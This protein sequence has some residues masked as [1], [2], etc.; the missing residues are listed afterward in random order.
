M[1]DFVVL[2]TRLWVPGND[3]H[4][5]AYYYAD[6]QKQ[7]TI[8]LYDANLAQVASDTINV[9]SGLNEINVGE[10]L[11]NLANWPGEGYYVLQLGNSF[12]PIVVTTGDTTQHL[13][14][15]GIKKIT[16]FDKATMLYLDLPPDSPY[17]P[18]SSRF[19]D[20]VYYHDDAKKLGKLKVFDYPRVLETD[21][22]RYAVMK[23]GLS[24]NSV[25]DV[26]RYLA[27]YIA[28]SSREAAE[29][30]GKIAA[31]NVEDAAKIAAM[32]QIMVPFGDLIN[33]KVDLNNLEIT[34]E[35]GV[36]LGWGWD[37][38]FTVLKYIVAGVV[39]GGAAM[40]GIGVTLATGGIGGLVIGGAIAATG[41]AIANLIVSYGSGKEWSEKIE[42]KANEGISN[43]T[44]AANEAVNTVD[45]YY[46]RG[47]I[48]KE[49]RDAVVSEINK[50][51]E[52]A[53]NAI[54][55]VKE[56]AKQCYQ[57]GYNDC[58]NK[59][60]KYTAGAGIGGAVLG[61]LIGRR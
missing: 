49:A 56:T 11:F 33:W 10:W 9:N 48:T 5:K 28:T 55:E 38:V 24:F 29:V 40:A 41:M 7:I 53:I 16:V 1:A 18:Y 2:D 61:L 13:Q 14:E 43:V 17:I 44:K 39:A 6:S 50:I 60:I 25:D 42:A 30:I 34:M 52:T 21:W 59:Y 58:K 20:I 36:R 4:P 37:S 57:A 27:R 35:I 22:A 54:N 31:N 32:Y 15:K 12:I 8:A 26:F 45:Y 46:N 23:I 19:M 51:K 3:L 47:E